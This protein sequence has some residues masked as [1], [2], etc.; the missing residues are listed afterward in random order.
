VLV[1]RPE[2]EGV[3]E[4][5]LACLPAPSDGA[6]VRVLDVGSGSGAIAVTLAAERADVH[7][8]AV[9]ASQGAVDVTC[10]NASRHGVSDR[11]SVRAGVLYEPF[12]AMRYHSIASNPPYIPTREI[13]TLAADVRDFE[14]REALDG[15]PEG[16]AVLAP[17]V[18]GARNRLERGGVLVVEIGYDQAERARTCAR[19]AGFEHVEL[20]KDLAG[21]ERVL[22]A[23]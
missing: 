14:P 10:A 22:V 8:D 23:R 9:D 3:V 19:A 2:T 18:A 1:P 20:R 5:V 15:G 17:L 21:I 4:A 16:D 12:A 11:V 13:A 7:V 6:T